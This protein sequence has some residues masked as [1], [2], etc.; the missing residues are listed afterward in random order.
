MATTLTGTGINFYA[1][2]FFMA[3]RLNE[4]RKWIHFYS[5]RTSLFQLYQ[6]L[7]IHIFQIRIFILSNIR[8]LTVHLHKQNN[9]EGAKLNTGACYY[10]YRNYYRLHS[11][12]SFGNPRRIPVCGQF[13]KTTLLGIW[14]YGAEMAVGNSIKADQIKDTVKSKYTSSISRL[15]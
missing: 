10:I 13:S 9:Y 15:L 3:Q 2:N 6:D 11:K 4:P 12:I 1:R 7:C 14:P 5:C 8:H